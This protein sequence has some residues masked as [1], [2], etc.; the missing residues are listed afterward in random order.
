M[1]SKTSKGFRRTPPNPA[2]EY[3]FLGPPGAVGMLV[4]LP[5]VTYA[6]YFNCRE[7]FGCIPAFWDPKDGFWPSIGANPASYPAD[8]WNFLSSTWDMKAFYVYSAYMAFLFISFFVIPGDV[9][10][11]TVVGGV[12]GSPLTKDR[13]NYKLKYKVN[14]LRTMMLIFALI[15][16]TVYTKGVKPFLFLYDHF[17][18]LI[19]ASLVWTYGL[20]IFVYIWSFLPDSNGQEKILACGGN[21]G[22]MIYDFVL[23]RELNPRFSASPD[24]TFDIKHFIELRPGLIGWIILNFGM[25]CKQYHELGRITN[26]MVAVQLL[27]AFYV[28]DSLWNE[29]AVLTTMDI[30]TDGFGFM[31]ANGLLTWLPMNYCIQARYLATFPLDMGLVHCALVIITQCIGYIIFRGA[32]GQKNRFRLY[33][34]SAPQNRGIKYMET[35]SGSKLMI[36]GWWGTARHFNYFGDWL[37]ALAWS[38]PCG[39]ASPL[40]YFYPIY[41]AALLFHRELRDAEKCRKKY[42]KDWDKYCEIVRW[43]I[44]PYIY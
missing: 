24:S 20:S 3:E 16:A 19:T 27:E 34:P 43:R 13:S 7:G 35:A 21:T 31:L 39:F 5:L 11:G 14:A 44:I 17:L 6:L 30:T 36:S 10:E 37:M 2:P 15:A 4:F 12:G 41:F 22:N 9:V 26:S 23:G 42:G 25:A 38:L 29:P 28:L 1:S 32:N 18:G 33:G 40:P 8:L